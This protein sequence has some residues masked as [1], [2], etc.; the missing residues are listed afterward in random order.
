[1]VSRIGPIPVLKTVSTTRSWFARYLRFRLI[2]LALPLIL[3]FGAIYFQHRYK[4]FSGGLYNQARYATLGENKNLW[5]CVS[6]W[7]EYM[8]LLKFNEATGFYSFDNVDETGMSLYERGKLAF[9]RGD[10]A[11][12]VARI[13]QDVN[14]SGESE[15]KLFLLAISHM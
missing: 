12:A 15:D 1:M 10:F 9:H 8:E 7:L 6:Y 4:G 11:T 14:E 13:E 3:L 2:L 5:F